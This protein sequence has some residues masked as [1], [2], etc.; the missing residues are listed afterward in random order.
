MKRLSP[1]MEARSRTHLVRATVLLAFLAVLLLCAAGVAAVA[2]SRAAGSAVEYTPESP[3]CQ[4]GQPYNPKCPTVVHITFPKRAVARKGQVTLAQ[5][6]CNVAC[7]KVNVL[8]KQ[9]KRKVAASEDWV[10]GSESVAVTVKLPA[11]AKK[12]LR[13]DGRLRVSV[14]VCVHPPGPEN[15][16]DHDVV[17]VVR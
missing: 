13:N 6:A 2:T 11:A 17:K 8:A 5:V 15:F 4:P 9:G 16:C 1:A 12:A 3:E 14:K 7:N 10:K